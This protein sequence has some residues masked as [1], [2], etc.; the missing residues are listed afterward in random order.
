MGKSFFTV[1]RPLSYLVDDVTGYDVLQEVARQHERRVHWFQEIR[2]MDTSTKLF[3]KFP[4]EKSAFIE[5]LMARTGPKPDVKQVH[6]DTKNKYGDFSTHSI[7]KVIEFVWKS[8][9]EAGMIDPQAIT[10]RARAGG[11]I[12]HAMPTPE[13]LSEDGPGMLSCGCLFMSS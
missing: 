7:N 9:E 5:W 4:K 3:S 12:K 8:K 2:D 11:G 13:D 6:I 1:Y 10:D